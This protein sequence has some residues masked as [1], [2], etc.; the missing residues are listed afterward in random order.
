[1]NGVKAKH[2]AAR[3]LL[4][5][6]DANNRRYYFNVLKRQGYELDEAAS[7][8]EAI[9]KIRGNDYDVVVS[10]LQMYQLSG[11]DVLEAAKARDPFTQVLIMTG[12]GSIP[13]AVLAMQ[14]GAFDYLS[15]P[16]QKDALVLR[17]QRALR[18]RALRLQLKEQQERIEAHN[19]MIERDL[20][21]AQKVQASLVPSDFE[22]ERYAVAIHYEPMIG[23]G[24]DFCNVMPFD[25]DRFI[26]NM[27]DVTGHGIA[28]AL[29]V[30]RVWNELE[31][32][33]HR[34]PSPAEVLRQINDFFYATF[35]K[36]GLFMTIFAL[37]VDLRKMEVTYAGGAHPAALV[38]NA[39]RPTLRELPSDNLIIGFMPSDRVKF[40]EASAPLEHGD[41]IAVYT[42]GILEAESEKGCCYSMQRLKETFAAHRA[43][44]A[45]VAC[46]SIVE[47]VKAFSGG[48][49]RDDVMLMLIEIK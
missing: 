45:A 19:R 47:D 46:R 32:V 3:I 40:F 26:V 33:L 36:M 39:N 34:Q 5:D 11:L 12:Y 2:S 49:L 8:E 25:E 16:V 28:A 44:P 35:S 4:V 6:D 43:E 14:Q 29:L 30:N 18:E 42:D 17:V 41:R 21:L 20:E 37:V 24:G 22:N 48:V 13:T 9:E 38:A 31:S 27:V 7:G 1:M 15:K 23:I 10:D